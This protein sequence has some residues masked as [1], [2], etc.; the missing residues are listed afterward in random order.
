MKVNDEECDWVSASFQPR[1]SFPVG[2]PM[3]EG[4][5]SAFALKA[6]GSPVQRQSLHWIARLAP[7][8][9]M[10]LSFVQW[11]KPRAPESASWLHGVS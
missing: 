4:V 1:K 9:G 2:S 5:L 8:E 6:M 11:T 3:N 10:G 7:W